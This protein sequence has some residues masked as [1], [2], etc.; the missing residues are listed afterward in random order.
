MGRR[1]PVRTTEEPALAE[2]VVVP[3]PWRAIAPQNL[4][5]AF[6]D[7]LTGR[8]YE[9]S[10]TTVFA[11]TRYTA[12]A[13]FRKIYESPNPQAPYAG[14]F[15][16]VFQQLGGAG[17]GFA[18]RHNY[19][20][21]NQ[22]N[23]SAQV[24][25]DQPS[26][27][28][29]PAPDFTYLGESETEGIIIA[30][31]V[32]DDDAYPDDGWYVNGRRQLGGAGWSDAGTSTQD[33]ILGGQ[34]SFHHIMGFFFHLDAMSFEEVLALEH[35]ILLAKDIPAV[36]Y[37]GF[38]VVPD[39]I[40]SVKRAMTPGTNGVASWVSDGATG[41]ETLTRVDSNLV[42]IEAEGALAAVR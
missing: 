27:N 36:D 38:G 10:G 1:F 19:G 33:F 28:S 37:S 7:S 34:G 35:N 13:V 25:V 31:I 30:T 20:A 23:W 22:N 39:H 40:W 3:G 15:A 18:L 16:N 11:R 17:E 5:E 12:G 41:G 9:Q 32:V 21:S 6:Q 4:G 26:S 29:N 2:G 24:G 14:S 8:A 42:V